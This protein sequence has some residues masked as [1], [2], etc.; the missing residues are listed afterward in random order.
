M[1]SNYQE[2]YQGPRLTF[3]EDALNQQDEEMIFFD[4]ESNCYEYDDAL[5][6]ESDMLYYEEEMC[7]EESQPPQACDDR[8]DEQ[9]ALLNLIVGVQQYLAELQT[10]GANN[11]Q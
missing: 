9:D 10:A 5:Y 11:R 7:Q 8:Q 6:E 2:C 3:N 1:S 4:D